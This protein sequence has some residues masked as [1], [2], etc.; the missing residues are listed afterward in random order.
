MGIVIIFILSLFREKHPFIM[1]ETEYYE[2]LFAYILCLAPFAGGLGI[3]LI[4]DK[5]SCYFYSTVGLFYLI[6]LPFSLEGLLSFFDTLFDYKY[7]NFNTILLAMSY[8][9]ISYY[10]LFLKNA[11]VYVPFAS[12]LGG[13]SVYI[14]RNIKNKNWNWE[15]ILKENWKDWFL[16]NKNFKYWLLVNIITV[17]I[18]IILQTFF[19]LFGL[20]FKNLYITLLQDS[21]TSYLFYNSLFYYI[22][23]LS[24]LIIKIVKP[25]C[26]IRYYASIGL[27]YCICLSSYN[28]L[29]ENYINYDFYDFHIYIPFRDIFYF[30]YNLLWSIAR[31]FLAGFIID[32]YRYIRNPEKNEIQ[33]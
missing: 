21:I 12:F 7:I 2:T 22:P 3:K 9:P 32:I 29:L 26:S 8:H 33:F 24:S 11:L 19:I 20:H 30:K 14:Y 16:K 6:T 5:I 10:P 23:F 13:S 31:T 28:S 25:D 17:I 18:G 15:T 27:I 1:Q 4:N